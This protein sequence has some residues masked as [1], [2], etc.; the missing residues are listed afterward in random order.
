MTA[1]DSILN[2]DHFCIMP[3]GL[4][5]RDG[6]TLGHIR[7]FERDILFYIADWPDQS[8]AVF[9]NRYTEQVYDLRRFE[10][11]TLKAKHYTTLTSSENMV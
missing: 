10:Q 7:D 3:G 6:L 9:E 2:G 1:I 8:K 5:K 11:A 4:V